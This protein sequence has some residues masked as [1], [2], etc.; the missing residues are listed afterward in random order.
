M[1]KMATKAKARFF[2][3]FFSHQLSFPV[4]ALPFPSAPL[5]FT[6]G[7]EILSPPSIPSY[8]QV[9]QEISFPTFPPVYLAFLLLPFVFNVS[10]CFSLQV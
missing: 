9:K 6:S 7:R 4:F 5:S 8:L 2:S 3:F 10:F 1:K